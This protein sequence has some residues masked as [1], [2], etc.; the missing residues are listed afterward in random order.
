MRQVSLGHI[1]GVGARLAVIGWLGANAWATT[2]LRAQDS[3]LVLDTSNTLV[4]ISSAAPG[5]SL[6]SVVITGLQA[7]EVMWAIDFRPANGAL[8]GLGDSNRLY[9]INQTTGAATQVGTGAFAIPLNG[10]NFGFDFNPITDT[11]RVTSDQRQNLR[12]NP[13]T[14]TVIV[15]NMINNPALPIE[16]PEVVGAAYTNPL[17]ILG[18]SFTTL[19]GIDADQNRLVRIGSANG[20]P[21]SPNTGQIT[22]INTLGTIVGPG[23]C[24]FDIASSNVAYVT[25]HNA[26]TMMSALY[27][28]NLMTGTVGLLGDLPGG[29]YRGLAAIPRP[30]VS[31]S[32][33]TVTE[34]DAALSN[35]VFNVTLTQS[36]VSTLTVNFATANETALAASDYAQKNGVLSFS[37]GQ[38]VKTVTINVVG[39]TEIEANETFRVN[40]SNVVGG[41]GADLVGVATILSDDPDGDSDGV[42]DAV[43]NCPTTGN[44]DQAD[45]DNDGEGDVCEPPPPPPPDT[46]GGFCAQGVLPASLLSL[47][48]MFWGGGP[49]WRS[50]PRI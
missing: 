6:G 23:I 49:Q 5:T 50:F 8:Y 39:D 31:I 18:G 19:F 41:V 38:K 25:F 36:P 15:D 46:G 12:I 26:A 4:R 11:I 2:A 9:I 1:S 17:V 45:A 48:L 40:L 33:T 43:D 28:V 22:G 27:T 3:L 21:A 29:A 42:R 20:T 10:T 37:P 30:R 14:A 13:T 32:N 7:A 34:G 44:P 35:A 16:M 24:G 47:L